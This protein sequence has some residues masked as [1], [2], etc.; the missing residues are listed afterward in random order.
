MVSWD[1]RVAVRAGRVSAAVEV[2]AIMPAL[3]FGARNFLFPSYHRTLAVEYFY[4]NFLSL[5]SHPVHVTDTPYQTGTAAQYRP[6]QKIITDRTVRCCRFQQLSRSLAAIRRATTKSKTLA[7]H[8][9]LI[10]VEILI[11]YR[12]DLLGFGYYTFQR[13]HAL[14]Q[15]T[16]FKLSSWRCDFADVPR[17]NLFADGNRCFPHLK[18]HL[19]L[20]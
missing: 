9:R 12:P 20:Y 17:Y 14:A 16:Q 5:L 19:V 1:G 4:C 8:H 15:S 3:F 18:D 13:R 7:K 6:N 10:L 11:H 2:S